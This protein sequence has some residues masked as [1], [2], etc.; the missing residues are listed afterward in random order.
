V[1]VSN[2]LGSELERSAICRGKT[3]G[4][5]GQLAGFNLERLISSGRPAIEPGAVLAERVVTLGR[6]A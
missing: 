6:D 4:G 3:V 5:S 2:T 1:E